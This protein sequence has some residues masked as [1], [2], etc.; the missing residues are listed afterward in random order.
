MNRTPSTLSYQSQGYVFLFLFP[1][2]MYGCERWT[3]KN[4]ESRRIDALE[5][6]CWRRLLRVPWIARSNQPIL[7]EINFE[8][9]LEGLMLK[10]KLQ[11]LATWYKFIEMPM[12]S[13][14]SQFTGK[15]PDAGTDRR[16]E[17][18]GTTQDEMD[19]LNEH[20]FEQTQGDGEGQG[21]L[22]GVLLFMGLQRVRHNLVT[23]QQQSGVCMCVCVC[24]CVCVCARA[25]TQSC[26]TL[27]NL[28]H[29][30]LLGS[31]VHAIFQARIHSLLQGIFLTQGSNLSLLC[32]LHWQADS[33]SLCHLGSL[34]SRFSLVKIFKIFLLLPV[35]LLY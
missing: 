14:E 27:C 9:S 28:V 18:K 31:S 32:L 24:V 30:S 15:D 19:R 8:Y 20:E 2:V 26:L 16:Q 12:N 17:K 1:V 7:K 10:L 34:P 13:M 22:P 29:Y 21:S 3:I 5:L 33:L 4:T 23:E 35:V 25:H 11:Y 6:W